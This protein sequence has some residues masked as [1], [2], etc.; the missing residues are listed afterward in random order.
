MQRPHL[1]S[2][3]CDAKMDTEYVDGAAYRGGPS[4]PNFICIGAT[5]YYGKETLK[6]LATGDETLLC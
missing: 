3:L 4:C 6:A 5:Q 2:N 1:T